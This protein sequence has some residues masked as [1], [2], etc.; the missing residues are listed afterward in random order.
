MIIYYNTP[1]KY[2]FLPYYFSNHL[3]FSLYIFLKMLTDYYLCRRDFHR[4]SFLYICVLYSA[5]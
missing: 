2:Q 3:I 5:K 4:H 1:L